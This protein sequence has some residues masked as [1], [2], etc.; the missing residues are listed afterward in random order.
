MC[1]LLNRRNISLGQ[2]LIYSVALLDKD[3]DIHIYI[4]IY[5]KLL[6]EPSDRDLQRIGPFDERFGPESLRSQGLGRIR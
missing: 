5:L 1:R 3:I 4:Y 2:K 6:M